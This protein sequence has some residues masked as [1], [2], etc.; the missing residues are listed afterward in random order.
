MNLTNK[1]LAKI[2][3]D[4]A[5]NVERCKNNEVTRFS[6][7]TLTEQLPHPYEI[8]RTYEGMCIEFKFKIH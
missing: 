2:L 8:F 1:E 3:R 5:D 4:M 7:E 6:F